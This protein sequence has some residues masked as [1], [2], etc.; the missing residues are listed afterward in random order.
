MLIGRILI[1]MNYSV[2][3]LNIKILTII[4]THLIIK[5]FF[6]NNIVYIYTYSGIYKACSQEETFYRLRAIDSDDCIRPAHTVIKLST[7][8]CGGLFVAF[9][10]ISYHNIASYVY[11]FSVFYF[12]IS[13]F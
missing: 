9:C 11:Q 1:T 4:C 5:S 6:V 13:L 2:N 3:A 12:S 8:N 7:D 10:S